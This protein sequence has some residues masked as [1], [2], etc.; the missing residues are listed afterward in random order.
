MLYEASLKT[1]EI[2]KGLRVLKW[3]ERNNESFIHL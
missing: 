2:N 1:Q 3:Q